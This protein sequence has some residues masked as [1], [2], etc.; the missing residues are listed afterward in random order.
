MTLPASLLTSGYPSLSQVHVQTSIFALS[1]N[2]RFFHD[3]LHYR[4]QRWLPSSHSLY[5]PAFANDDLKAFHPFS[6]GPRACLGREMAWMQ[7]KLFITKVLWTFDLVKVPGQPFD[8]EKSLR[9]YGFLAKS[10]LWVRFVPVTRS[11][12]MK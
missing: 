5:D 8:L 10:E 2:P 9:H 3:P 6:L 1:R 7:A 12:E 4:P 11:N